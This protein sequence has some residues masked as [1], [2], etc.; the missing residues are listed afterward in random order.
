[1]SIL[2]PERDNK[3]NRDQVL[4]RAAEHHGI[5]RVFG[6]DRVGFKFRGDSS[7]TI[8]PEI[9]NPAQRRGSI[10]SKR[11]DPREAF[12]MISSA[13]FRS[14]PKGIQRG[15][16]P[17]H[18]IFELGFIRRFCLTDGVKIHQKAFS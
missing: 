17:H 4:D 3:E 5:V 6:L 9:K 10:C 2:C 7:S 1:M 18:P 8:K 11:A 15:F 16:N 12:P 13:W 14:G